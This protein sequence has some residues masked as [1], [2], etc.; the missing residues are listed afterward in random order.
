MKS[1][2]SLSFASTAFDKNPNLSSTTLW[3]IEVGGIGTHGIL[4]FVKGSVSSNLAYE[5]SDTVTIALEGSLGVIIPSKFVSNSEICPCDRFYAGGVGLYG[6][7]GFHQYGMGPMSPRRSGRFSSTCNRQFD[8]L[9]G[10]FLC[11]IL[12]ALRFKLP[13]PTLSALGIEGQVFGNVGLL[14]DLAEGSL[15]MTKKQ[16]FA[17]ENLRGTIGMG[18]FWPLQIGQLE[19][20]ICRVINK[21]PRDYAKNGIQFGITPY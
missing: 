1:S 5:V 13:I 15:R 2:A 8:S 20:N 19:A 21:G 6:L 11:S 12:G 4:Q 18:F 17:R 14:G 16:N 10:T 7:R 3:N 9:G